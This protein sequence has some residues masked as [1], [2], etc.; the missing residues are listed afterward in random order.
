MTR[1]HL[2]ARQAADALGINERTA[3][4]WAD[5]GAFEGVTRLGRKY[6]I[7][8]AEVERV[9]REGFDFATLERQAA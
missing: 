7:P 5:R 2:T 1:T 3:A 9:Q 8:A 6:R 4:R